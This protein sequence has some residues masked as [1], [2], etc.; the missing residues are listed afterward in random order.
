MRVDK[1]SETWRAIEE[2]AKSRLAKNRDILE[3]PGTTEALTNSHRGA[4]GE[5]KELLS[6]ADDKPLELVGEDTGY[7]VGV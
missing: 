1:R 2:W 4:I 6:L 3:D 7:G 5:L